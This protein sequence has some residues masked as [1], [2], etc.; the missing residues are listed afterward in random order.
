MTLTKF[1]E[2]DVSCEADSSIVVQEMTLLVWSLA[3]SQGSAT[4]LCPEPSGSR[5]SPVSRLLIL[6]LISVKVDLQIILCISFMVT[7]SVV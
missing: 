2:Q 6:Y 1:M 7:A 3:C 5:S 4:G